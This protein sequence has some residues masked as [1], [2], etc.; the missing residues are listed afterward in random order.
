SLRACGGPFGV[1]PITCARKQCTEPDW[2]AQL[3]PN[4]AGCWPDLFVESR[5]SAASLWRLL[6]AV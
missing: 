2:R 4:V 6:A 5:F 1:E 3:V